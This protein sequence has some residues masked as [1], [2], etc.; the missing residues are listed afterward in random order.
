M[1]FAHYLVVIP[2]EPSDLTKAALFSTSFFCSPPPLLHLL[3]P[4]FLSI[5]ITLI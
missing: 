4:H 1:A 3:P 2:T 5:K